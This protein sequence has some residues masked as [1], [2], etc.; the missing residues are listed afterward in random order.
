MS[1]SATSRSASWLLVP[2]NSSTHRLLLACGCAGPVLFVGAFLIE[3]ATRPGYQ[4][5][6][7]TIS[8]LMVGSAGWEQRASFFLFGVLV[9]AFGL[10]LRAALAPGVGSLWVPRVK[11][12]EGLALIATGIFTTDPLHTLATVCSFSLALVSYVILAR[13][14]AAEPRWRGWTAYSIL[15]GVV[16][17]GCL[18]TFGVM[19]ANHGPA[20]LFEKLAAGTNGVY[21]FALG[22]RLLTTRGRVAPSR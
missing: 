16:S 5:V 22:A 8:A 21:T 7:E 18:V 9:A 4:P 15:T 11:V 3:G 14:F 2:V 17:V 10:G 12:L 13:R 6:R 20:G 1:S 19:M